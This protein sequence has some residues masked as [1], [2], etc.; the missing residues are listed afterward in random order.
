MGHRIPEA[1]PGRP[2]ALTPLAG[3]PGNPNS[4]TREFCG[5]AHAVIETVQRIAQAG[6]G[7]REDLLVI[8]HGGP[9]DEPANV[10][11]ALGRLPSSV[12]FFGALSIERLPTERAITNQLKA[13]K[14]L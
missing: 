5:W 1:I 4:D 7:V 11:E 3:G 14:A 12:G 8:C 10:G 2:L 13:F 9:F 6:H